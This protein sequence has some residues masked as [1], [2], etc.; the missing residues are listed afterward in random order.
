MK[1]VKAIDS[2]VSMNDST[3]DS[4]STEISEV[5]ED[6]EDYLCLSRQKALFERAEFVHSIKILDPLTM[7]DGQI[8]AMLR[9]RFSNTNEEFKTMVD[10]VKKAHI[11]KLD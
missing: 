7:I 10:Q 9:V 6:N 1:K 3:K 5:I 4:Q 2:E 8:P 11:A